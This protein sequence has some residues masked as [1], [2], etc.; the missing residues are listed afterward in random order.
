[1]PKPEALGED[2]GQDREA[3]ASPEGVGE[4]EGEVR[5]VDAGVVDDRVG[6]VDEVAGR[7]DHRAGG[8]GTACG[9]RETGGGVGR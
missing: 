5:R 3:A 2:A 1:M 4:L 6:R 7:H 9:E 8:D